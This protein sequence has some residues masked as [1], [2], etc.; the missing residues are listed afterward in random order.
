MRIAAA[1]AVVAVVGLASGCALSPNGDLKA[2]VGEAGFAGSSPY[3]CKWGSSNFPNEPKSWYGCWDYVPGRLGR[4]SRVVGA[5]LVAHGFRVTAAR[6]FLSVY[7][8]AVRGTDT[9]CVDV[10][11]P[12]FVHGR[13]TDPFEVNPGAREVF[14]DVWAVEPRG[15]TARCAALPPGPDDI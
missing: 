12:G 2:L 11:A 9:L 1:V 4:V 5:R 13:N 8:T 6:G 15:A 14:V 10:L 3:G 7:L